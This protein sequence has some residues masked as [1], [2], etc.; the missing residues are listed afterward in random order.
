VPSDLYH[1]LDANNAKPTLMVNGKPFAIELDRGYARIRRH[2]QAG[3]AV[4]L[5][6]PMPVRR[7][8]SHPKI[9]GNSGRVAVERGPVLYCAEEAD[10]GGGIEVYHLPDN[11]ALHPTFQPDL[12]SGCVTLSAEVSGKTVTLI[13]YHL[14]GHR[15]LGQMAVWLK[16]E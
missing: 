8:G 7:V 1:Y 6:L 4:Q 3:D 9:E 16:R 15:G 13:P 2:W 11:A 10:N 5:H 14:W 12:L